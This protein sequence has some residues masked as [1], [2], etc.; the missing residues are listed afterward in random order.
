MVTNSARKGK[1]KTRLLQTSENGFVY[2]E[3]ARTWVL[4]TE[5]ASI[6]TTPV[7]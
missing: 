5:D 3:N 6:R 4:Y 7:F 1:S 2:G